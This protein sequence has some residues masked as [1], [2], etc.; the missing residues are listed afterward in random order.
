MK[1]DKPIVLLLLCITLLSCKKFLDAKPNKSLVIPETVKDAEHLLNDFYQFN[2]Q[3][4]NLARE[5]DDNILLTDNSFSVL[6]ERI[7]TNYIWRGD[8]NNESEWLW[9]YRTIMT[10]NIIIEAYDKAVI[11]PVD[12]SKWNAVKGAA[13]FYRANAFFTIA[14]YFAKPYMQATAAT[15]PGIPL[16][17]KPDINQP[18]N[19]ASLAETFSRIIQDTREAASLLPASTEMP[20]HV[21]KPAALA[22]LA[23]AYLIM[24]DYSNCLQA[25]QQ[26]LAIKNTLLDY[27]HLQA[28]A[29]FP[30]PRFNTEVLF[31]MTPLGSTALNQN[32]WKVALELYNLY[33]DNDLRKVIFFREIG[34]GFYTFKGDYNNNDPLN[35]GVRF[36]GLTTSEIWLTLAECHARIGNIQA[37]MAALNTL[38]EKRFKTGTFTPFTASTSIAALERILEERRKELVMRSTRWF[39]LRRLNLEPATQKQLIRMVNGQQ[40]SL[41]PN[42]N[43]YTFLIPQQVISASG[44]TQNPR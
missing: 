24:A 22:L 12:S 28:N 15:D 19:R 5:S 30:V 7:R 39:D 33:S 20:Y 1:P 10:A 36:D 31:H 16:K 44:I 14:Q 43:R 8:N 23:R 32:H 17:L 34:S 18:T 35:P 3:H 6:N 38:M 42:D 2:I 40:Y 26:V 4:P 9:Q 25:C 13:L 27:N 29:S 41:P 21:S 11:K 37:A